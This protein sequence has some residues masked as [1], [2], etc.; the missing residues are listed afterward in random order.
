M[1]MAADPGPD[2]PSPLSPREKA[3]LTG[4]ENDLATDAALARR[5]SRLTSRTARSITSTLLKWFGGL[6][7]ALL[8]IPLSAALISPSGWATLAL[9]TILFAV[10]WLLKRAFE[11]HDHD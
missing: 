9:F 7:A 4:I 11:R 10:P 8:I 1:A 3:I 2:E 6:I 5:M